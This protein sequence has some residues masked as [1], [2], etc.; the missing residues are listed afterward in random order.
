MNRYYQRVTIKIMKINTYIKLYAATLAILVI[1]D[2]TWLTII[3]HQLY[4][5]QIGFLLNPNPDITVVSLTYLVFT[6]GLLLFV[7]MPSLRNHER[8][9]THVFLLGGLFG[10]F[11]YAAYDLTN[12]STVNH[13]PLLIT[14]IDMLWGFVLSGVT[15]SLSF[16]IG[17]RLM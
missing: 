14:I 16:L 10:F 6:V 17:K 15:S 3:A 9:A 1:M 5:D 8:K 4:I 11:V 13:W 2:L 12:Y 7:V